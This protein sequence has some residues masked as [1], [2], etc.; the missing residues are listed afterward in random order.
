MLGC[1]KM[2]I[3]C[4]GVGFDIDND[5][6]S[7]LTLSDLENARNTSSKS[8]IAC[9]IL[10]IATSFSTVRVPSAR[11]AFSSKKQLTP[12]PLAKKYSSV[13]RV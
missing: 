5:S 8:C 3:D 13:V 12:L 7:R 2:Y 1:L 4:T 6:M 10:L 11:S 9:P